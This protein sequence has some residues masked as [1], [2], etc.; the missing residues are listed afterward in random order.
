MRRRKSFFWSNLLPR[1][2]NYDRFRRKNRPTEKVFGDLFD[3]LPFKE[4]SDDTASLLIAGHCRIATNAEVISRKTFAGWGDGHR[5]MVQPEQI[6]IGMNSITVDATGPYK[7]VN[8]TASPGNNKLYGT[9]G[10]G[11]RG[12]YDQATVAKMDIIVVSNEA[13]FI[14]AFT[15]LN[16]AGGGIIALDNTV[17]LT[18]DRT[19]DHSSIE[20][21]GTG[22]TLQFNNY[23]INITGTNALYKD[24]TLSGTVVFGSIWSS[25]PS[26]K[27]FK[28]N[29]SNFGVIS[30]Q[31]VTFNNCVGTEADT[32]D[33]PVIDVT[34]CGVWFEMRIER[35]SVATQSSG[36]PK[37]YEGFQVRIRKNLTGMRINIYDWS[38]KGTCVVSGGNYDQRE[39]SFN[40]ACK[41]FIVKDTG[42]L[43]PVQTRNFIH[44]G[45]VSLE[46]YTGVDGTDVSLDNYPRYAKDVV[47]GTTDPTSSVTR[48]GPGTRYIKT[49][50]DDVY[51]KKDYGSTTN[52][53]KVT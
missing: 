45:S 43:D 48:G 26:Q 49:D 2:I 44:D 21:W 47:L 5:R 29:D 8:D 9:N 10:S 27:V 42:K 6:P 38:G 28:I 33:Y 31:D 52:W 46:T 24:I 13:E 40:N 35:C 37:F 30:L 34:N 23:V 51:I 41:I 7:L 16:A 39:E 32:N 4:E 53:I 19:L 1:G 50:T 3:S 18:A 11:V 20:V 25:K 12:W 36:V 14:A 17:T 22:N 15:T